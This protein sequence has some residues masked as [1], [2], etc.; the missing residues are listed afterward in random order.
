MVRFNERMEQEGKMSEEITN[1]IIEYS[2]RFKTTLND[3]IIAIMYLI[4]VEF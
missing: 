4:E 2:D 3:S 1:L